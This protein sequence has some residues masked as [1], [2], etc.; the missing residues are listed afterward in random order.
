MTLTSF[1][2]LATTALLT[3][4]ASPAEY[5][6]QEAPSLSSS[7]SSSSHVSPSVSS[8]AAV[9]SAPSPTSG[10][11]L[12]DAPAGIGGKMYTVTLVNSHSVAINTVH[13]TNQNASP[14]FYDDRGFIPQGGTSTYVLPTAVS[15][16]NL[17]FLFLHRLSETGKH[18]SLTY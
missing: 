18:R 15:E 17:L 11:A 9:A 1:V 13:G 6:R 3:V 14:A 2:L 10:L 4:L 16:R 8:S 5:A 7:S 12:Q